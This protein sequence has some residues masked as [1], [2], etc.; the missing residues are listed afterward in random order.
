M[1]SA[2]ALVCWSV[3]AWAS[4]LGRASAKWSALA[5]ANSLGRAS[6]YWMVCWL[7]WAYWWAL[8]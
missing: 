2:M 6:A 7:D 3:Q 4:W 1:A 8:A 5:W